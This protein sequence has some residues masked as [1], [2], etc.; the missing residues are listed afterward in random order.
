MGPGS[1]PQ[2]HGAE[3]RVNA[4]LALHRVR[5]TVAGA[6]NCPS[7]DTISVTAP[8]LPVVLIGRRQ[9]ELIALPN[10]RQNP[11]H[12]VPDPEGR[13]AIVTNVGRGGGGRFGREDERA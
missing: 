9:A 10:H 8:D 7:L 5:D 11:L 12:P 2:R 1:A 3:T 6:S 13:F 4:L